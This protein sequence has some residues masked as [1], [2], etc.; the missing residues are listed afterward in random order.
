[1]FAQSGVN[2]DKVDDAIGAIV[3]EF[4][5]IAEEPV[6]AEELEK[7]RNYMK[8]RFVFSIETPQGLIRTALYDEV[9]EGA[10][11]EPEAVLALM[12]AVTA[13]DVQRVAQDILGGGLY[14]S[15]IGPFDDADRFERLI[16]S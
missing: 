9:L 15:I 3:T 12:D 14:L 7:A 2:V 13:E 11:R 5:R 8:G 16:A 10:A 1:M 4:R 6:G